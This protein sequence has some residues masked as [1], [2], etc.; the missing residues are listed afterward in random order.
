MVFAQFYAQASHLTII[1]I[2][3]L[4]VTII[5]TL[6]Y[7]YTT[8]QAKIKRLKQDIKKYQEKLKKQKDDPDKALKIQKDMMSINGQLMKE[9]FKP[10]IY[11]FI[12]LILVFAWMAATLA[13]MPIS[14]GESF[15]VSTTVDTDN[16]MG[17]L[18]ELPEQIELLEK[19]T[20]SE[21]REVI[22]SLR[23][24]EAGDFKPK[25]VSGDL[26]QEFELVI[27]N[28]KRYADPVQSF[29]TD[30]SQVRIS[31]DQ[32]KPFGD[33]SLFGW[34]PGWLGAYILLSIAFSLIL[35]KAM[36]IA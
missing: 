32:V 18:I 25:I 8:D 16:L 36:G 4:L 27:S 34:E 7:K 33:F 20:D 11:T 1:I 15:E 26:E 19:T 35:R 5:S 2:L 30:I 14:P 3:S 22:F 10:L 9:S 13:F 29:N 21:S 17:V 31:H 12:P 23:A 28:T 6:A 24:S